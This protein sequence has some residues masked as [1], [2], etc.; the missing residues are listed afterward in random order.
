MDPPVLIGMQEVSGGEKDKKRA[1]QI[2]SR[3]RKVYW[4]MARHIEYN[5][6]FTFVLAS[7]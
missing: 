3:E 1:H 7:T 6:C 4:W 5:V 2:P